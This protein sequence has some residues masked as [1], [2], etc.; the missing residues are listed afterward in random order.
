M[1]NLGIGHVGLN[2]DD[3]EKSAEFYKNILG[4]DIKAKNRRVVL[5]LS[6]RDAIILHEKSDPTY[7]RVLSLL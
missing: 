3:L 5:I 7:T 4:L 6:G 1:A 2:V